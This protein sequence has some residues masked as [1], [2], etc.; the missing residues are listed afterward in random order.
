MKKPTDLL[1]DHFK[2]IEKKRK[3]MAEEYRKLEKN[4]VAKTKEFMEKLKTITDREKK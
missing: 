4:I 2:L 3:E 1:K